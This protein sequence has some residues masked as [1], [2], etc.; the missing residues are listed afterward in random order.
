MR[1]KKG[2]PVA[3]AITNPALRTIGGH[4]RS[5]ENILEFVVKII[6]FWCVIKLIRVQNLP[7]IKAKCHS[8]KIYTA[9]I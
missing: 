8:L 6:F 1:V 4:H 7:F 5:F 3:Y 2:L 9:L